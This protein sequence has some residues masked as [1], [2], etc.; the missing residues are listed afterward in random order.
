MQAQFLAAILTLSAGETLGE[1]H[2][3]DVCVT[4]GQEGATMTSGRAHSS[5]KGKIAGAVRS[6]GGSASPR[7]GGVSAI[8]REFDYARRLGTTEA[9]EKFIARNPDHP[10]AQKARELLSSPDTRRRLP[11]P[12]DGSAGSATRSAYDAA[13]RQGTVAA[14]DRFIADHPGHPLAEQAQWLR[15]DLARQVRRN[16]VT[17]GKAAKPEL[18]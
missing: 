5:D 2:A 11:M 13:V 4:A 8:A 12:S 6:T 9:L 15:G 14:L 18:R 16:A 17:I 1:N 7:E 3:V 10:L